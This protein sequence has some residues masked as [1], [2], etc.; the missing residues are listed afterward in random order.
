MTDVDKLLEDISTLVRSEF[1]DSPELSG[2]QFQ[3]ID[4]DL[5]TTVVDATSFPAGVLMNMG[6][7]EVFCAFNSKFERCW[8]AYSGEIYDD[9]E[10]AELARRCNGKVMVIHEACE[11]NLKE[12]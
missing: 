10:F 1:E 12:N 11:Y 5:N 8:I 7:W 9:Y 6:G 4:G 2:T 3:I